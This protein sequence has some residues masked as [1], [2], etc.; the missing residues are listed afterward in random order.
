MKR[1]QD[2]ID[3]I[4]HEFNSLF[5]ELL[6]GHLPEEMALDVMEQRTEE[7]LRQ[8]GAKMIERQ[9]EQLGDGR[10]GNQRRT[11]DG[12]KAVFKELEDRTITTRLGEVRFKSAKYYVKECQRSWHP[13][14]ERL[15]IIDSFSPGLKRSCAAASVV[16]PFE[17]GMALV[18]DILGWRPMSARSAEDQAEQYG[19]LL[20]EKRD[21]RCQEVMNDAVKEEKKPVTAPVEVMYVTCD[22]TT[23]HIKE[24]GWKEAKVGAVYRLDEA[25]EAAEISYTG[26]FEEAEQFGK[27]LY[28]EAHHRGV[29]KAEQV[30]MLGDGAAWIRNLKAEHFPNAVEIL[31]YAHASEHVHDLS[32][33]LFGEESSEAQRWAEKKE[34]LL[35][36]GKTKKLINSLKRTSAKGREARKKLKETITYFENN[37]DRM[38]YRE[39]RRKGYHIGSGIAEAACKQLV[40]QRLKQ[41]GMRWSREGAEAMLQL[42]ILRTNRRWGI[43]EDI[44]R[45]QAAW[46]N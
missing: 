3:E 27:V 7:A 42:K 34:S 36:Q 39:Y 41:S 22:G 23:T 28:T 45:E 11:G 17:G 14:E 44:Q 8:I 46:L 30:V 33:E 6:A 24:E 38:N 18:K 20:K 1:S 29:E 2:V 13:L 19:S 35:F 43:L 40:Q 10:E 31:D 4:T 32:K 15:G 37:K 5:T 25:G 16:E 12:K 9:I 21:E 26:G